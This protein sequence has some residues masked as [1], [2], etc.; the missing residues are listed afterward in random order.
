M[1]YFSADECVDLASNAHFQLQWPEDEQADQCFV[2]VLHEEPNRSG[3]N[4][5]YH[6][7]IDSPPGSHYQQARDFVFDGLFGLRAFARE[8][9]G[10]VCT[11]TR[12]NKKA[13]WL[14]SVIHNHP[15]DPDSMNELDQHLKKQI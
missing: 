7:S 4:H 6:F 2:V 10:R 1:A 14:K 8:C 3:K 12:P 11:T 5:N 13:K 9:E 15:L